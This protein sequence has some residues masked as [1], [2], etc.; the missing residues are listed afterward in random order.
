LK[1]C[2]KCCERKKRCS[3]V[4]GTKK[5][6]KVLKCRIC[7]KRNKYCRKTKNS[8]IKTLRRV[9][10]ISKQLRKAFLVKKKNQAYLCQN[11][12]RCGCRGINRRH[13]KNKYCC[14]EVNVCRR[15]VIR[16]IK[17]TK[18]HKVVPVV[19]QKKVT[20]KSSKFFRKRGCKCH[21][22]K[23]CKISKKKI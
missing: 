12:I 19:S 17:K 2:N 4:N 11:F 7:C 13:R 15:H 22:N 10:I 8:L 16:K 23:R 9:S 5:C 3:K 18:H 6:K 21:L 20:K 1:K 14:R